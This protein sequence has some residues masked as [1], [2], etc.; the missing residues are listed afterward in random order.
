MLDA[1]CDFLYYICPIRR[2]RSCGYVWWIGF[3]ESWTY[4]CSISC[5]REDASHYD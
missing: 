5:Y 2:C 4:Y 3:G 1:I